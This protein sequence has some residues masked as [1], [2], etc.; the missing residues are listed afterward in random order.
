M[1]SFI[2]FVISQLI[3]Y[4]LLSQ[5]RCAEIK[6]NSCVRKFISLSIL[7]RR[8]VLHIGLGDPIPKSLLVVSL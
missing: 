5:P 4:S 6:V 3:K 7:S 8:A 1:Y 2:N